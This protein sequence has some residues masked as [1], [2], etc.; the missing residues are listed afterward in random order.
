MYGITRYRE[1][2]TLLHPSF[3]NIVKEFEIRMVCFDSLKST[4]IF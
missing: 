2:I 4:Q 3:M 1:K